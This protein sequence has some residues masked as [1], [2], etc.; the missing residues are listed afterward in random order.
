MP[1]KEHQS[2]DDKGNTKIL[3]EKRALHDPVLADLT[4]PLCPGSLRNCDFLHHADLAVLSLSHV[5]HFVP[6]VTERWPSE[7]NS[8]VLTEWSG[9]VTLLTVA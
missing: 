7:L 1:L 5:L 3:K 9:E 2:K 8:V 4:G 6:V